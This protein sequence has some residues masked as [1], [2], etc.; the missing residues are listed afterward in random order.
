MRQPKQQSTLA[1]SAPPSARRRGIARWRVAALS[2]EMAAHQVG[3]LRQCRLAR[4]VKP[5]VQA[6]VV[7]LASST[8]TS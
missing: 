3:Q 6:P 1:I 2:K 5:L 4:M 7:E 8:P